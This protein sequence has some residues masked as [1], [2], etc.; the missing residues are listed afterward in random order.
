[1][2]SVTGESI[3]NVFPSQ[4]VE[5]F[6]LKKGIESEFGIN[7]KRLSPAEPFSKYGLIDG[8]VLEQPMNVFLIDRKGDLFW[9]NY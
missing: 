1:M 2:F 9:Y 7:G 4:T 8:S 5:D 3:S 6:A